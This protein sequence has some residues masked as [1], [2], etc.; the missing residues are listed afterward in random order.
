VHGRLGRVVRHDE[1]L[2]ADAASHG[3]QSED[4]A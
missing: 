3:D 2:V 4:G 1:E